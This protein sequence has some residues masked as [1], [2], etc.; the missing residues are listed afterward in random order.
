MFVGV[1]GRQ[2][3]LLLVEEVH[4]LLT[5]LRRAAVLAKLLT[6]WV[7]LARRWIRDARR[8]FFALKPE[9]K[10]GTSQAFSGYSV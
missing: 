4:R 10:I 6:G 5:F 2:V 7:R 8:S 9:S 1:A 3:L